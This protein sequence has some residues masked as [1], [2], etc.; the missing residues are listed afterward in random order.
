MTGATFC[1]AAAETAIA[2][3]ISEVVAIPSL[4]L[5]VIDEYV[6]A[7]DGVP[8]NNPVLLLK[9][10]QLGWFETPKVS[11]LPSPSLAVG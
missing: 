9:V 11:V 8:D 2:N 5:M 7:A 4:A 1:W 10:A 3:G 6:P